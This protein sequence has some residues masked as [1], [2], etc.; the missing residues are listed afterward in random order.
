MD[1]KILTVAYNWYQ[2]PL[3]EE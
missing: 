1:N 3:P 2:E